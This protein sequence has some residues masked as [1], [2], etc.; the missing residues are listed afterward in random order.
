MYTDLKEYR[1][2]Y[3]GII[4]VKSEQL[5]KY[6]IKGITPDKL[7]VFE[8]DEAV[9]Q[10]N[11]WATQQIKTKSE[12]QVELIDQTFT[13]PKQYWIEDIPE[14]LRSLET[15]IKHDNLYQQRIERLKK[16]IHLISDHQMTDMIRIV[17]YVV[18]IFKEK[19]I[20]WGVGRGS[21]C[22]SYVLYLMGLHL[23]DPVKYNIAIEDFIKA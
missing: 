22:S 18:T 2:W 10:Y 7:A 11:Q 17:Y 1:L 13:I 21:S 4:Q 16:E 12:V 15:K 3:D 6:L 14:Y 8:L 23:V 9:R 5:E 19:N 20:I